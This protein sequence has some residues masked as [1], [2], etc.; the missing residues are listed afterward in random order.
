MGATAVMMGLQVV[1]GVV[2]ANNAR[3]QYNAQAEAYE[4]NAQQAYE[5]AKRQRQAG[6]ENAQNSAMNRELKRQGLMRTLGS[7]RASVGAGGLTMSGSAL[8]ALA[9]SKYAMDEEL[10]MDA[11]NDRQ[12]TDSYMNE[13]ANLYGQGDVYKANAKSLRKAGK[14]AFIN[15]LLSTGFTL[16]GNL[17]GGNSAAAV[18]S[19]LAGGGLTASVGGNSADYSALTGSGGIGNY[20]DSSRGFGWV[21]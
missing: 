2:Q 13:S 17:Y 16:A 6:F 4:A 1:N 20:Y 3:K 21:G 15:G 7:Q 11:Y 10:G 5:N 19:A 8:Q 14:R 9:Q 18:G 12:R